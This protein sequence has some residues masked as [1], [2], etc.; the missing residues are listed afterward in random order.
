MNPQTQQK[1]HHLEY[2]ARSFFEPTTI[3]GEEV[4]QQ[5]TLLTPSSL[6]VL[7]PT[8]Y[9]KVPRHE[10]VMIEISGSGNP[11]SDANARAISP[12]S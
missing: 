12:L 9:K 11:A 5:C 7:Q 10:T 8:S 4:T 3:H 2:L 1:K 6:Q